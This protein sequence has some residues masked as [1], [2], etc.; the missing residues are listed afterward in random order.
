MI[1]G[2]RLGYG[3]G[4]RYGLRIGSCGGGGGGGRGGGA[5]TFSESA[6]FKVGK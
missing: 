2:K 5:W 1:S 4:F 6:I 3:A